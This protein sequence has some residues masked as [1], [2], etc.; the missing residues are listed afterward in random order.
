MRTLLSILGKGI[1]VL[2]VAGYGFGFMMDTGVVP[3]DRVQTH[4]QIEE[5]H[6]Q[7]LLDEGII[8][9]GEHIEHF[10]S[11][12]LVS[13]REGGSILTDRRVI[14]YE[15]WDD[16]E[17]YIY[18]LAFND[19]VDIEKVQEGDA[20]NYAVYTVMGED[21]DD[22]LELWLP[23]EHGDADRFVTALEAKVGR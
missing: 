5:K 8:D 3:S 20:L 1:A 16:D 13:V 18:E 15:E 22:Y 6:M 4:E 2:V 17:I 7:V 12:G 10:Y 11:E 9:N 23:H 14:A 19:I 21:E